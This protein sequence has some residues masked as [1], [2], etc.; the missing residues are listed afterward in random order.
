[1]GKVESGSGVDKVNSHVES[2]LRTLDEQKELLVELVSA[3]ENRLGKVLKENL[4]TSEGSAD[5]E[6]VIV[7]LASDIRSI[8]RVFHEQT[9]QL[10]SILERL[11]L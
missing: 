10:T 8:R 6:D 7:P 1:M 11:E 4:S 2:E 9:S 5:T 3:L